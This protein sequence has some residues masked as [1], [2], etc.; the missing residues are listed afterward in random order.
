MTRKGHYLSPRFTLFWRPQQGPTPILKT[1]TLIGA[2]HRGQLSELSQPLVRILYTISEPFQSRCYV[3]PLP[4]S[5][6][7]SEEPCHFW[8]L[9]KHNGDRVDLA[10]LLS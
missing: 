10:R 6:P 5:N 9:A 7:I 1:E 3:Y 4:Q 8:C 2:D